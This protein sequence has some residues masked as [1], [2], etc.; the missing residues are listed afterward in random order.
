[1]KGGRT[2]V[3]VPSSR[4]IASMESTFPYDQETVLCA[5]GDVFGCILTIGKSELIFHISDSR[6][7]WIWTVSALS[8][9]EDLIAGFL[10]GPNVYINARAFFV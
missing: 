1:M 8:H 3:L 6:M 7:M 9:V 10:K 4:K 5:V 2:E